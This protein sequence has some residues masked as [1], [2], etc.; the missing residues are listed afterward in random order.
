MGSR[1]LPGK[2]LSDIGAE[3]LLGCI[4][5]RIGS[6]QHR[7]SVVVATTLSSDDNAIGAYARSRATPCFRGSEE[8][9]LRRYVD[10]AHAHGFRQVVRLTADNPFVDPIELDRLIDLHL[11]ER[12]D[13]S[14]SLTTL[15]VGVGAE[16]FTIATLERSD[17]EGR[18]PHHREHVNEYL[19]ENRTLFRCRTLA[20]APAK[21]RPDVRLTVDTEDDRRV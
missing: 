15:P 21:A 16:I 11:S 19:I 20:V 8:D 4:L 14:E 1:R 5:T 2:V 10:C 18:L 17:R 9:V 12:A 3:P 6:L 13:Y 7:A